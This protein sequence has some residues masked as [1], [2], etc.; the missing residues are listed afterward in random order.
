[1]PKPKVFLSS[2]MTGE[3]VAIRQ[4]IKTQLDPYFEVLLFEPYLDTAHPTSPREAYLDLVRKSDISII[5]VGPE[6]SQAVEQEFDESQKLNKTPLVFLDVGLFDETQNTFKAKLQQQVLFHSIE[7][8]NPQILA[9]K[10]LENL[11]HVLSKFYLGRKEKPKLIPDI[12]AYPENPD[13]LSIPSLHIT[14]APTTPNTVF[15]LQQQREQ[16]RLIIAQHS[17]DMHNRD[18]QLSGQRLLFFHGTPRVLFQE[19]TKEGLI[20][21]SDDIRN[22]VGNI[23]ETTLYRKINA[24]LLVAQKTYELTNFNSSLQVKVDLRRVTGLALRT[25]RE[26]AGPSERR[27]NEDPSIHLY[28]TANTLEEKAHPIL[29]QIVPYFDTPHPT[30]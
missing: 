14:I 7:F 29:E 4:E 28:S 8:E 10:I 20:H 1:M 15:N 18:D 6:Y 27:A 13:L 30:I 25:H 5:L 19:I 22:G 2:K 12:A 9:R 23:S 17:Y 11:I 3:Y 21:Y 16:L 26:L 24:A